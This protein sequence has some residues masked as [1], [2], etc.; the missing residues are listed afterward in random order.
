MLHRSR[1]TLRSH[2]NRDNCSKNIIDVLRSHL[3]SPSDCQQICFLIDGEEQESIQTYSE[4]L[5][6]VMC[7]AGALRGLNL[8]GERVQI[9]LPAGLSYLHAMLACMWIGAIAIP[10]SVPRP[11]RHHN[12]LTRVAQNAEACAMITSEATMAARSQLF[13]SFEENNQCSILTCEQLA[14]GGPCSKPT[15]HT[16]TAYLQYTSGSTQ[17]PKGVIVTH[18]N[19]LA[20]CRA[21]ALASDCGP[22]DIIVSWLPLFHDMGLVG[23]LF[24]SLFCGCPFVFMSPE[25]FVMK[26]ARWLRA[27]SKY[28]GTISPAPNFAYD[29]CSQKVDSD[30]RVELDLSSWRVAWNGAETVRDSSIELFIESFSSCGFAAESMRPCYGLAESTLLVSSTPLN[31]R[32]TF[33]F[34]SREALRDGEVIDDPAGQ[35]LVSCGIPADKTKI[36]I[37]DPNNRQPLPPNSLGEIW[38]SGDSVT[39]GYWNNSKVSEQTDCQQPL[40]NPDQ[41]LATGDLGFVCDGEL[42]IAG[43]VKDIMILDGRNL[44]PE[45]LEAIAEQVDATKLRG[46]VIAFSVQGERSERVILVVAIYERHPEIAAIRDL[47]QQIRTAISCHADIPISEVVFVRPRTLPK[48]SSGKKQR[49]EC[50]DMYR[51]NSLEML[52]NDK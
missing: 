45:D 1:P 32:P 31:Q 46:C 35:A 18:D 33:K 14:L 40:D 16:D 52:P 10:L 34:V 28:R 2:S 6:S 7:M 47:E 9:V 11:K 49:Q 37:V 21:I 48:T 51:S 4:L 23:G 17:D 3:K 26:P 25:A 38:V 39:P 44:Y 24:V 50:R 13:S 36:Q 22:E 5:E 8:V 20:N 12:R 41:Y 29:L 30:Q 19:L 15:P 43:R 27:I 42:Y